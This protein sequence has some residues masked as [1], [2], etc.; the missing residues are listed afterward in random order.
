MNLGVFHPLVEDFDPPIGSDTSSYYWREWRWSRS[1]AS[2]ADLACGVS[3]DVS[4]GTKLPDVSSGARRLAQD[5]SIAWRLFTLSPSLPFRNTTGGVQ[6]WTLLGELDKV[7]TV[8]SLRFTDV[9]I[10][11]L[12]PDL[13]DQHTETDIAAQPCLAFRLNCSAAEE[14]RVTAISPTGVIVTVAFQGGSCASAQSPQCRICEP[15]QAQQ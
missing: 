15:T 12:L 1:C 8:S 2:A 7:V 4:A 10:E 14:V 11:E 6:H 9:E 5:G 3:I 13:V